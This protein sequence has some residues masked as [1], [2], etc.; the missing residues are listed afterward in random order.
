MSRTTQI[1]HLRHESHSA[2]KITKSHR[3]AANRSETTSMLPV[4]QAAD[5]SAAARRLNQASVTERLQRNHWGGVRRR[6]ET[7][8]IDFRAV[9]FWY[10]CIFVCFWGDS[11]NMIGWYL[12]V[13]EEQ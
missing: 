6:T 1:L 2:Q 3:A 13:E 11:E 9:K 4:V 10:F 5:T 8:Y 7:Q 12:H